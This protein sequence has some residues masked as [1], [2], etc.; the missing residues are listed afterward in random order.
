MKIKNIPIN[1]VHLYP[2]NPREMDKT[3]FE[4]LKKSI[5]VY[6]ILKPLI[7]NLRGDK[8]FTDKEKVPTI[9]GGNMRWRA[10]KALGFKEIPTTEIDINKNKEAMLNIA[11][12][13][14]SGK[15]DIS[16]LEK[17]VYELSDKDL[18]LD[19][20]LTGL[21][22]WEMRLYNPAEDI[23]NEEIA[24]IIGT[25]EKPTHIMKVI[26]TDEKEFERISK[27]LSGNNKIKNIVR[28]DKLAKILSLEDKKEVLNK[29]YSQKLGEVIY[30]PKKTNH[31]IS[32]LFQAEHKFDKEINILKNKKIKKML[33]ARTAYFANFNYSKIADYFAYQATTEEQRI[34]EKLA[35]VLLDK[36]KL[37]ENGFSKIIDS[38]TNDEEEK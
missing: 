21:E 34:F 6:G 31:K 26:F 3:Q 7:I 24:E 33:K 27:K 15:W 22:D 12:N 1:S 8:S 35:L 25:D 36:D 2:D 13:R 19:L 20:D 5:Q 23:D 4:K 29:N 14:I 38:V 9:V 32:D 10:C 37:I 17:M 30:K 11:L 28:G 16:K 18:D